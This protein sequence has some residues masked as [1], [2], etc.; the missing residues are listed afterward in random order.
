ME[1][2][3]K[4]KEAKCDVSEVGKAIGKEVGVVIGDRAYHVS[5]GHK[6]QDSGFFTEKDKKL[7]EDSMLRCGVICLKKVILT[8]SRE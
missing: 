7:L 2:S 8:A 3:R 6:F 1:S 5:L 4:K